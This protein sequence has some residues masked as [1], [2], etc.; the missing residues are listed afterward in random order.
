MMDLNCKVRYKKW[1]S[2]CIRFFWPNLFI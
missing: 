2:E 1:K